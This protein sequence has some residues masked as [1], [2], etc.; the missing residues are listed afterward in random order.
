M[1]YFLQGLVSKGSSRP[2]VCIFLL[3][4]TL[5]SVVSAEGW[6]SNEYIVD[7]FNKITMKDVS[8]KKWQTAIYYQIKHHVDDIPLHE[9]L[10]AIQLQ[11][12]QDITGLII[13]PANA[14]HK[15]NMTIVLTTEKQLKTDIQ[16]Y[17]KLTDLSKIKALSRN[18]I[19]VTSL[20][21]N[22][23]GYIEHS[24]VVIPTDRARAYGRL[25]TSFSEMLARALGMQYHS[26]D[27]Y[28]SIFNG[29]S[30]DVFLTGLDYIMLKLLYDQRVK[31]GKDV[32]KM[33]QLLASILKEKNYQ[34]DIGEATLAVRKN[35]LNR[36]IN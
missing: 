36:L 26:T 17:L 10:V 2:L 11:Q 5:S 13:Q 4:I 25:L 3:L 7:S 29:R 32:A 35:G 14:L 31:P 34:H 16:H 1:E 27:V 12:L 28:P 18:Q 33:K 6:Q 8:L 30:V 19:G 24:I 15:A 20:L 21:T 22:Q 9:K 23:N